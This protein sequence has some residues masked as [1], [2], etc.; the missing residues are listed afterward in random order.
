MK[1]FRGICVATLVATCFSPVAIA[2]GKKEPRAEL[3]EKLL[4]CR[5]VSDAG[6]RL[7]CYDTG[8][9]AMAAAAQKDELVVVDR[10]QIRQA[11]R[12]LFG[13]TLPNLAIFGGDKNEGEGFSEIESTISRA[14]FSNYRWNVV[15]ADGAKWVQVDTKAPS[16]DP[17]PGQAIKIRRAALGSFL[18]NIDGQR[19][20]RMRREN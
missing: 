5:S 6:K 8:V 2:Q 20:I 14:Y 12:S 15:L 19:A 16:R 10:T 3:F 13:L 1:L 17:K 18:A 7:A 11:R 4:G 9:A